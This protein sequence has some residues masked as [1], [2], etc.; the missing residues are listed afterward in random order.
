[1]SAE[2]DLLGASLAAERGA[3]VRLS[4]IVPVYNERAYVAR[5]VEELMALPLDKEV[6]VV[7]DGSKDGT[8]EILASLQREQHPDLRL[9]FSERN[10]GKGSA[11]RRG[12]AAASG[13]VVVVQDADMEYSPGDLGRML[14]VLEERNASVVYGTRFRP[15]APRMALANFV[16]NKI[17]AW[18]ATLLF[19]QR[20]TDEATC[21]K[22]FRR[23]LL[24]RIRL[25]ARSF[26]FC[27]EVTAKV[28]RLGHHIH[29]VPIRYTARTR[30]EG[31]KISWRDGFVAAWTLVKYRFA[32]KRSFLVGREPGR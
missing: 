6:I 19:F 7:D 22:M 16:A 29:E 4:I 20:I 23:D 12:F 1:V 8:G 26:D 25:V 32:P 11:L 24:A 14:R 2:A 27:P 10:E 30:R 3:Q 13:E 15:R 5:V 18:M 31:R 28:K 9:I 17:L 21:Y